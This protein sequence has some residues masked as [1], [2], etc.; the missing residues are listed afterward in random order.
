MRDMFVNSND[1]LKVQYVKFQSAPLPVNT[2]SFQRRRFKNTV[3]HNTFFVH[4]F[5]VFFTC[6]LLYMPVFTARS[7]TL[8]INKNDSD[9]NYL[10]ICY[11]YIFC[12]LFA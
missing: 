10:L 7:F 3:I 8:Q 2:T 1:T 9:S 4:F 5:F 12:N 6:R 11:L